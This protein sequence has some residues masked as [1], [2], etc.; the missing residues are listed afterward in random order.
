VD[1]RPILDRSDIPEDVRRALRI[2]L[3]DRSADGDRLYRELFEKSSDAV[4]LMH[5]N[6]FIDCNLAATVLFGAGRREQLIGQH[7]SVI[8][9]SHQPDRTPSVEAADAHVRRAYAYGSVR[10]DWVH[11]HLD[12]TDFDAEVV[13]T[14]VKHQ[15]RDLLHAIVRDI[16]E[17][18]AAA[19]RL[20]E[21]EA[22]LRAV[23]E[24]T[25]DLVFSVDRDSRLLTWNA[26]FARTVRAGFGLEVRRGM[27][28]DVLPGDIREWWDLHFRQALDGQRTRDDL[29]LELG[30]MRLRYHASLSPV[31]GPDGAIV[32]AS[33]FLRDVAAEREAQEALAMERYLLRSV[34]DALPDQVFVKDTASRFLLANRQTVIGCRAETESDVLGKTDLDLLE[35]TWARKCFEEEQELMATGSSFRDR[36]ESLAGPDGKRECYLSTKLPLRDADGDIIGLVGIN[37]WVTKEREAL[38]AAEESEAST[39]AVLRASPVATMVF[40]DGAIVRANEA[41]GAVTG[42]AAEEL[43]GLGSRALYASSEEHERAGALL[44]QQVGAHGL[45]AL[46]TQFL[47]TDGQLVDVL[48]RACPI[49]PADPAGALVVT[50]MDITERKRAEEALRSSEARLAAILRAAPA[51]IAVVHHREFE[52]VSDRYAELTGHSRGDLLGRSARVLYASD[53]EFSRVGQYLDEQAAGCGA[54]MIETQ[55]VRADGQLVG[56][57]LSAC[58]LDVSDR[59]GP[60]VVAAMDVTE[61]RQADEERRRLEADT[62]RLQRLESIGVLAGGIAHD[63]NNL[64]SA[65]LG[66]SELAAMDAPEGSRERQRLEHIVAAGERARDLVRQILTFSRRSESQPLAVLLQPIVKESLKFLRASLPSTIEFRSSLDPD[67]GKVFVDPTQ[68]HQVVMNL[69]TNAGQ[70][71]VAAGGGVL[72]VQLSEVEVD[73]TLAERLSC[74][75]AG[76]YARLSVSDTGIG[77]DPETVDRIFEP[78]FTTKPS[79][80]GTGLGLSTVHGV[81][82]SHGG[83]ITVYSEPDIGTTFHVYL[84]V[85]AE[86]A[87]TPAEGGALLPTGSERVM[88]VDD[89]PAVAAMAGEALRALG[90][91]V[92]EFTDSRKALREF[93]EGPDRFDLV[94]TDQTMPHF[95]GSQLRASMQFLRPGLP[96]IIVT[97]FHPRV[98]TESIDGGPPPVVLSKPYTISELARQVRTALDG[99]GI[100]TG[101]TGR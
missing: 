34:V 51:G 23:L 26:A 13:L 69:C 17:R 36:D 44:H 72:E 39:A 84:P 57:L 30:G 52:M 95:T 83:G 65:I 15:G 85:T 82:R 59:D 27:G 62:Q 86:D 68:F 96:V 1:L 64:L 40:R 7:P 73:G 88:V 66:F 63:F 58:P 79:G 45:A 16:S 55:Y 4:L 37:H 92:V 18:R 101:E 67:C 5:G 76:R 97:G 29:D 47:R 61:K 90:Y 74:P 87:E 54:G 22:N 8:S 53:D 91:E 2:H 42:R 31:I 93:R 99:V 78:F 80:E 50:A 56:V 12:G 9:P 11:R 24:N 21:S 35:P 20:A 89:E 60:V 38:R 32:G 10:F 25:D 70:A 75:A 100:S 3:A 48:V 46:E 94:L 71:L 98:R 6:R 33:C 28:S 77:M 49:D 14:A 81:V 41:A 43:I 19:A